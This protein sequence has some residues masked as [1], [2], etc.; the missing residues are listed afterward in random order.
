MKRNVKHQSINLQLSMEMREI[1]NSLDNGM[2]YIIHTQLI[3]KLSKGK[4]N[5]ESL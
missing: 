3:P 5:N 1:Q 2:S 4:V